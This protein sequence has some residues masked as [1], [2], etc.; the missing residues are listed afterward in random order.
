MK[1]PATLTRRFAWA[2]VA[3]ALA[4]PGRASDSAGDEF[5]VTWL[6]NLAAGI[7]VIEVQLTSAVATTVTVEHPVLSPTFVT[8]VAV[9][10]GSTTTV[11]IPAAASSAWVANTVMNNAVRLSAP[12]DFVAQ[13]VNRKG[14]TSD[15]ALGIPVEALGLEYYAADYDPPS[16][17]P[18]GQLSVVA[19]VDGTTVTITPSVDLVGHL[20]GIPFNVAL[21]RGEAY[22]GQ[23]ATGSSVGLTGTHVSATQPVGVSNGAYCLNVP[24]PTPACDHLFEVATPVQSYGIEF[25]AANLPSRPDGTV[26]RIL[27]ASAATDVTL[28]GVPITGSPIDAGEFLEVGPLTGNHVFAS[29]APVL[30]THY[31]TGSS[32][33]GTGGAGDPSMCNL[34]P[35]ER[36]LTDTRFSTFLGGAWASSALTQHYL[37][38]FAADADTATITLNAVPIGSGSFTSIPGTGHSVATLNVPAGTYR[39]ESTSGH[40]VLVLGL[41]NGPESY[42][43]PAGTALECLAAPAECLPDGLDGGPCCTPAQPTVRRPGTFTQ[44]ALGICWRDCDVESTSRC[45]AQWTLGSTSLNPCAIRRMRVELGDAAGIVKWRGRVS[46]QYSRTWREEDSSGDSLQVW[47]YLANGD[48]RATAAAGVSPCPVPP[49]AAAHS[50]RVRFTGYV[51]MAR[52]CV[53]PGTPAPPPEYAWMLTHAC[54][55]IDHQPG[56]PRAG[57]FHPDRTYTFLGPAAGFVPT[58]MQSIEAGASPADVVRKVDLALGP[59]SCQHEEPAAITLDPTSLTCLCGAPGSNQFAVSSLSIAGSCGTSSFASS[60]FLPGFVSMSIGTWTDPTAY[61]G[62][63]GLRWNAG[64][65]GID[66]CFGILRDELFFGVTTLRGND[67][68]TIPSL[69]AAI[70]VPLLPTFVDQHNALR[71]NVSVANV[72]WKRSDHFI[73]INLP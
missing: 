58:P 40:G 49:C 35:T 43:M 60:T 63:E 17:N 56:F 55:A 72:P 3:L 15:G 57:S 12:D 30:V 50:G 26:Y 62:L 18:G 65:Y 34:I 54:D 70:P 2:A 46:V 39:T 25:L 61:P 64:G 67:A 44:T 48:L 11:T 10:P 13:L 27:A 73:N 8:S 19:T 14:A 21:D 38:V 51:D 68:F 4:A 6:P 20:A 69:P 41:S 36:F 29:S 52:R 31:V 5:I 71:S 16:S 42:Y 37:L 32:S 47:R 22:F 7:P 59:P 28:D 66:D 9:T 53:P 23:T 24:A 1:H 33:P 45:T